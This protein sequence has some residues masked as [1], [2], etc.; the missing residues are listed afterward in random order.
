MH[1][2]V[3]AIILSIL[4]TTSGE[5]YTP[6]AGEGLRT[7]R[8]RLN[9]MFMYIVYGDGRLFCLSNQEDSW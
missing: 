2:A 6:G 8:P 9:F 5:G 7:A 1:A 4:C 3:L